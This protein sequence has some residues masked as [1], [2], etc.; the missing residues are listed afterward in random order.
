V[1]GA[2]ELPRDHPSHDPSSDGHR[3]E[4]DAEDPGVPD[5]R[6]HRPRVDDDRRHDGRLGV[7]AVAIE[8]D[9][10]T[11]GVHR[12]PGKKLADVDQEATE[13]HSLGFGSERL[14][15]AG[16]DPIRQPQQHQAEQDRCNG[17]AKPVRVG[18]QLDTDDCHAAIAPLEVPV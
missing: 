12:G 4:R 18:A 15:A 13:H 14:A 11:S 8:D 6:Q 2:Q 10:P 1:R 17:Q 3:E 16:Q 7:E 9:L 5:L